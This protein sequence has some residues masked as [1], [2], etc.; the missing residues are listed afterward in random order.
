MDLDVACRR[1]L[2]PLQPFLAW[3]PRARP[4]GVNNDA[5]ASRAR[6]PAIEKMIKLLKSHNRNFLFPYITIFWST[7]PQF[8]GDALRIW[9]DEQSAAGKDMYKPGSSKIQSGEST[10]SVLSNSSHSVRSMHFSSFSDGC[11]DPD[12]IYILPQ[13]FYSE[14]YTFFGHNPGGTWHEG[15]VTTVLWLIAHPWMLITMASALLL[16]CVFVAYRRWKLKSLHKYASIKEEESSDISRSW[17]SP[18]SFLCGCVLLIGDASCIPVRT[19]HV[20]CNV[21]GFAK[22]KRVPT[23]TS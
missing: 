23:N 15:D 11:T 21:L 7:G 18:K 16:I 10:F 3:L 12:E 9:L 8:T 1:S 14:E 19:H 13:E 5:M 17:H 6:H 2:I 22:Q 4:L 20:I